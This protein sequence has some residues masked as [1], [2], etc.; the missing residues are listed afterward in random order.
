MAAGIIRGG[1]SCEIREVRFWQRRSD[2]ERGR[3]EDGWGVR[4]AGRGDWWRRCRSGT[5]EIDWKLNA[6]VDNP[7][8]YYL[9]FRNSS[10]EQ[11]PSLVDADFTASFE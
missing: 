11:G 10:E 1:T 5:G 7:Q 6:N 8:K 9:V 4:S 3:R 2:S